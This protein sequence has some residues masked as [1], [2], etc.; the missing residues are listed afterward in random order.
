MAII[1]YLA[2]W[3]VLYCVAPI[4]TPVRHGGICFQAQTDMRG[5]GVWANARVT[6]L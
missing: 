6:G 4:T 5:T 1:V 2:M 3:D